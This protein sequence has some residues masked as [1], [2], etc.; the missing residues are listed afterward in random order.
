LLRR[1][2]I[3]PGQ[4]F[5][6]PSGTIHAIGAGTMI[7]ETQQSSDITYRVYDYGR[8]D[9]NGNLR[10]LHIDQS[11]SVTTYPHQDP[12]IKQNELKIKDLYIKQFVEENYFTVYHWKIDGHS[13]LTQEYPFLQVSIIYRKGTLKTNDREFPFVKGDHLILPATMDLFSIEGE[14]EMIVSHS[15]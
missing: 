12:I 11:I 4:F 15:L 13:E 9:D 3:Q 7:L 10:E 6:V 5:H 8:M 14:A 2:P 1:V